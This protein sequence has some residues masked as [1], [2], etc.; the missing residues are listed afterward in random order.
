MGVCVSR[1]G[2]RAAALTSA[3]DVIVVSAD[4]F[5]Q[6]RNFQEPSL[7]TLC[8]NPAGTVLVTG[9]EERTL[10][11]RP[12]REEVSFKALRGSIVF[13]KDGRMVV[14]TGSE[15]GRDPKTGERV[16]EF[17]VPKGG[18]RERIDISPDGRLVSD[19]SIAV[20]TRTGSVVQVPVVNL[21][22]AAIIHGVA[23][24]PDSHSFATADS[25]RLAASVFDVHPLRVRATLK[26]PPK[27]ESGYPTP[28]NA[29]GRPA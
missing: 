14:A 17:P 27:S 1:D 7:G 26:K 16:A 25:T 23:F 3:A 19:G 5:S 11:L 20:E 21:K 6:C 10:R 22:G 24:A 15:G 2:R 9:G 18:G 8:L 28:L 12:L 29:R 4:D 13:S